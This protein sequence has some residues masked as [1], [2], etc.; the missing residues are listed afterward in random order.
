MAAA[1]LLVLSAQRWAWQRAL[2]RKV[3]LVSIAFAA[4]AQGIAVVADIRVP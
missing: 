3:L 4:V 2:S 1:P